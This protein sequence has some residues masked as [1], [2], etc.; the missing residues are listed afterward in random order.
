MITF[1]TLRLIRL[2]LIPFDLLLKVVGPR[3][4]LYFMLF[5]IAPPRPVGWLGRLRAIRASDNARRR[6]PAYRA[7]LASSDSSPAN[8]YSLAL[9]PTDKD[10]YIRAFQ[11]EDRCLDGRLPTHSIAIDES[12]GSTGTPYRACPNK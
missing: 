2:F 9:P 12:S 3:Y 5:T 1:L 8:L 10:T 11:I 6:V 7:F 4:T